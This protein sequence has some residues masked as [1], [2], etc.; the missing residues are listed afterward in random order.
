[1][2][3]FAPWLTLLIPLIIWAF[4]GYWF[5]T[6]ISL[7]YFGG[8]LFWSSLVIVELLII[9][10]ILYCDD[11]T[12]VPVVV[13]GVIV[14]LANVIGLV[15][16]T[17]LFQANN[18]YQQLGE[19][20]ESSFTDSIVP[21][22]NTQ[23]P[24]VDADLALKQAEKKLGE[25]PG[26]G[27]IVDVGE[28]TLQQ[29]DGKLTFVAPLEH[30]GMWKYFDNKTTPGY[31]TVS[32]TDPDDVQ[33]VQ[34]LDGKEIK[35]RYLETACFGDKLL[36]HIRNSGYRTTGLTDMSF[37]LDE[38][39]RPYWTVTTYENTAF[40][41][42][43]EANGVLVCDAQTGE[44]KLYSID[45][46]PDWIDKIQPEDF[47]DDQI[48]NYGDYVKGFW[49]S[50]FGKNGVINKTPGLLTVYNNGECY[51]YTGMT[52]VGNDDATT[53]FLMVNTRTKEAK[54][55]QMAGATE[56]SA[57]ASAEGKIQEKGYNAT[58][59]VPINVQ[60]IPT[61][62]MT[63]KDKSGLIKAYAMV[64]IENYSIVA[65]GESIDQVQQAY[66]DAML[67]N[68]NDAVI[69]SDEAYSYSVE[70]T[71]TR[72]SANISGGNT[73][74]Y[75]IINED[76]TK[77]YVAASKL[78]AELPITREGD[79]VKISYID[80]SNG[81]VN[82]SKFDNLDFTQEKSEEQQQKD[83]QAVKGGVSEDDTNK[84][85]EVDPEKSEKEWDSLTDEEKAKLLEEQ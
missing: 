76:T 61:Y 18:A 58:L 14:V 36:R 1:M 71:V 82:V 45:E 20:E 70:G 44:C 83:E 84:I 4:A 62:F 80:D 13:V 42:L 41:G 59:P 66:I 64:N 3:R 51:Y 79:N 31:I 5:G 49:N 10:V 8:S 22:D 34:E 78:S 12:I 2:K 39:G 9:G 29:V 21:I 65:T 30:S 16:G 48:D 60:G 50:V 24:T 52:S 7:G 6:N 33:L 67:A 68:G 17:P 19:V 74:Y 43:P 37:E 75:M 63:L 40:W 73:I 35:L 55:F 27:S 11:T 85:Y 72:I 28:F 69:G 23:I 54:F 26:L 77:L 15:A 47:I 57:Q 38:S 53:G 81:T 32:A 46:A 56:E 25:E